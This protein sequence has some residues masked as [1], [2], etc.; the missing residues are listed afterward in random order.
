LF[1]N[2]L[3]LPRGKKKFFS[4]TFLTFEVPVNGLFAPLPEVRC[5]IFLDILNPWGKVMEK[6]VSE[7]KLFV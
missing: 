6:V 2:C 5:P 1:E 3:K 7:M 4:L